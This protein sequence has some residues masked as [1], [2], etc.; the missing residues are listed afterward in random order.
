MKKIECPICKKLYSKSNLEKHLGWHKR[1]PD[2]LYRKEYVSINHEGLNCQYC[3]K[4]CKSKNSL[5]QHEIRCKENPNKLPYLGGGG[6]NKGLT[7]NTNDTLKKQSESLKLKYKEGYVNPRK[8]KP[9]TFLGKHHTEETKEKIRRS[10]IINEL[11]GWNRRN[12]IIYRDVK[13]GS[14]YEVLV[15]KEL[16]K[17]NIKWIR[18]SYLLYKDNKEKEHRYYP[19]F[20]LPDYDVYLDPKN[21]YL[22]NNINK[23]F[24]YS[25]LQKIK[26]VEEQNKVK[27]VILNKDNLKWQ[28]I[29]NLIV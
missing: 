21:D 24:G 14:S 22:L 2:L 23:N 20:Y 3:G 10:A 28:F 8:G 17:N 12:Q 11:G 27:I 19:D 13:L 7:K 29:Y 18:P 26:W 9:G 5:A 4:L 16:D 15:A 1:N 6:W 25:D